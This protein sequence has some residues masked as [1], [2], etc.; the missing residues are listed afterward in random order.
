MRKPPPISIATV[1]SGRLQPQEVN[2]KVRAG[3]ESAL[4]RTAALKG[5]CNDGKLHR[6]H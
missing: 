5:K 1:S 2:S 3:L 4:L 6:R